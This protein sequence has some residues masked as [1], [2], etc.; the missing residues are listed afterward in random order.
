MRYLC[1]GNSIKYVTMHQ[2]GKAGELTFF[3]GEAS[4]ILRVCTEMMMKSTG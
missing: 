1:E 2:P 4:D 3:K